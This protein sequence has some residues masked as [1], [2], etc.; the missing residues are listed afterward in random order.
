MEEAILWKLNQGE[1]SLPSSLFC[2]TLKLLSVQSVV[3]AHLCWNLQ[4]WMPNWGDKLRSL[5]LCYIQP[6]TMHLA[7][8]T[9]TDKHTDWDWS[10][11]STWHKVW[12]VWW[13][14]EMMLDCHSHQPGY[15]TLWMQSWRTVQYRYI[16][17]FAFHS[18]EPFRRGIFVWCNVWHVI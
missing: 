18:L 5:W 4:C 14:T 9:N 1:F 2:L 11:R 15:F 8:H 17:P 13:V 7:D 16:V 12:T 10:C 6:Y 3:H